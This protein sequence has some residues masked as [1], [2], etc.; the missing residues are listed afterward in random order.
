MKVKQTIQA[1]IGISILSMMTAGSA[2]ADTGTASG[3]LGNC[4]V[5]NDSLNFDNSSGNFTFTATL[6]NNCQQTLIL[7]Q[8][9]PLYV[10][11]ILG[12]PA[13]KLSSPPVY[14]TTVSAGYQIKNCTPPGQQYQPCKD[15]YG[16]YIGVYAPGGVLLP[17]KSVAVTVT[18]TA[19]YL[20]GYYPGTY[21][22]AA[23]VNTG[24][25]PYPPSQTYYVVAYASAYNSL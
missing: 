7:S 20:A 13:L 22:W 5:V 23:G 18:G 2:Y 21:Q 14:N 11:S 6:Y 12:N 19:H 9:S 8:N 17:N 15:S 16:E 10:R 4:I 3:G 24:F 1:I 25:T